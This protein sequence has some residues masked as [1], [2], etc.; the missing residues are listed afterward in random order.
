MAS[1]PLKQTR[2][3]WSMFL[4]AKIP[5]SKVPQLFHE[6]IRIH[7]ILGTNEE[8]FNFVVG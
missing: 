7:L 5:I 1:F 3:K 6:N 2:K 8:N 4:K